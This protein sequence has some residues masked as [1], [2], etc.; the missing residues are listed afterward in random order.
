MPHYHRYV[1][2]EEL[3]EAIARYVG[4]D[5]L[6]IVGSN[7]ADEMIDLVQRVFFNRGDAILDCPP[8]FEMY[9][10]FARLNDAGIMSV[11]RKEDFSLNVDACARC[12]C[13]FG[14]NASRSSQ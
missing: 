10:F 7:G 14:A 4:V 1:G 11:P 12:K 9:G 8:S 6:H 3:R 2:Q 5:V 13:C